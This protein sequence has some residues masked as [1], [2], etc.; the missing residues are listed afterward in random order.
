MVAILKSCRLKYCTTIAACRG[1]WSHYW[2]IIE[3]KFLMTSV[4]IVLLVCKLWSFD[5]AGWTGLKWP[6]IVCWWSAVHVIM[7]PTSS[8][9]LVY[10]FVLVVSVRVELFVLQR[11]KIVGVHFYWNNQLSI[12][13]LCPQF[14]CCNTCNFSFM[15]SVVTNVISV[16]VCGV[17]STHSFSL[18]GSNNS[19][20]F[21]I[22]WAHFSCYFASWGQHHSGVQH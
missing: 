13:L 12:C 8:A 4:R 3:R 18:S 19:D 7:W 15:T 20:S 6:C 10:D 2:I 21:S 11:A 17:D 1:G 9:L 16:L 14:L 5:S 22:R